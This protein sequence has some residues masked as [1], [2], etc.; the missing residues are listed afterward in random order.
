MCIYICIYIHIHINI[1]LHIYIHVYICIY[2]YINVFV[3]MC[4][5]LHAT[6]PTVGLDNLFGQLSGKVQTKFRPRIEIR[7]RSAN[8]ALETLPPAK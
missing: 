1:Y 5:H 3:N 6:I 8:G 7:A 2:I 4:I